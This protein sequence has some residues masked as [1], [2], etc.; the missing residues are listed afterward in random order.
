MLAI[1]VLMGGSFFLVDRIN[2]RLYYE[3]L[4]QRLNG[5]IAMYVTGER[6]LIE[7]G[8]VNEE[9][10]AQ[11]A[12]Q[13]MVVNPTV[14]VYLL[15]PEG[16]ILAH[17]MSPEESNSPISPTIQNGAKPGWAMSSRVSS[18]RAPS[19]RQFSAA[20]GARKYA[21]RFWPPRI[22]PAPPSSSTSTWT[23][24]SKEDGPRP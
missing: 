10:L 1:V 3:E 21:R 2:T 15:D 5:S 11:L 4:T 14:E 6:Q 12:R 18:C 24:A 22:F 8:A 17:G 20:E 13:A 16:R 19:S 9:A 7:G 23:T